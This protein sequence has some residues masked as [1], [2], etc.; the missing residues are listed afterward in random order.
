LPANL[1]I[2]SSRSLLRND[3]LD[4]TSPHRRNVTAGASP[5]ISV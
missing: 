3:L 4:Y 5:K 1:F 2:C